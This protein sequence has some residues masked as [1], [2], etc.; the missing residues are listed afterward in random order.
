MR[1]YATP[2]LGNRTESSHARMCMPTDPHHMRCIGPGAGK[3]GLQQRG[4]RGRRLGREQGH[5]K[6]VLA[7]CFPVRASRWCAV[8]VCTG[9]A[10]PSLY[11]SD[12]EPWTSIRDQVS[13]S[14][15]TCA[16]ILLDLILMLMLHSLPACLRSGPPAQLPKQSVLPLPQCKHTP[17]GLEA[18]ACILSVLLMTLLPARASHTQDGGAMMFGLGVKSAGGECM[19]LF[20][21][22]RFLRDQW[23][24]TLNMAAKVRG[25]TMNINDRFSINYQ[26]ALG[27]GL[28]SVVL[29]GQ[30]IATGVSG[31]CV[32]P[33]RALRQGR[34]SWCA[35]TCMPPLDAHLHFPTVVSPALA[36]CTLTCFPDPSTHNAGPRGHQNYQG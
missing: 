20:S 26:K 5:H 3:A 29:Q 34:V 15:T 13:T 9:S 30:E 8:L 12:L 11:A 4:S 1:T 27:S 28:F 21:A 31:L 7:C 33:A 35:C 16:R 17:H 18:P 22:D 36:Q 23:V 19:T 24:L 14:C 25:G 6:G 10:F 32:G 2:A